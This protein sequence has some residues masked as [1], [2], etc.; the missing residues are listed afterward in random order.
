VALDAHDRQ[1][2]DRYRAE[3]IA[4]GLDT[5]YSSLGRNNRMDYPT[6]GQLM[7]ATDRSGRQISFLAD[8]DAFQF[9]RSLQIANRIVPVVGNVAGDKA[10]RAIGQYAAEHSLNISAFYLSNVEQYLLTR[11][12]GFDAYARNVRTLPHDSTSVIIRS[13]FGRFGMTHPLFVQGVSS[14]STSMI[15]PIDTF[16]RA[17]AAGDIRTYADLVFNGYVTP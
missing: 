8:E 2:I 7:L 17:V 6:F 14:I 13:Y 3:F 10:V 11:D 4:D 9:V 5:R 12:G 16:L 15:E 1:M